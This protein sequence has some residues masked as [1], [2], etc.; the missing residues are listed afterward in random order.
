MSSAVNLSQDS[1][2]NEQP[3]KSKYYI[4]RR[5]IVIIGV[6]LLL[7]GLLLPFTAELY[8]TYGYHY[9][10][11]L[12]GSFSKTIELQTPPLSKILSNKSRAQTTK[13]DSFNYA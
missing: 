11:F 4:D 7:F 9:F 3:P 8:Y 6:C 10:P 5:W 1:I 12:G 2:R 13:P